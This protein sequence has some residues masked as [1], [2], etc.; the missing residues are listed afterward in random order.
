[1]VKISKNS[2]IFFSRMFLE[3]LLFVIYSRMR[4]GC[5]GKQQVEF[6]HSRF[7]TYF[8]DFDNLF[9][10][11]SIIYAQ[12]RRG[13]KMSLKVSRRLLK[14]DVTNPYAGILSNTRTWL[15]CGSEYAHDLLDE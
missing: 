14:I 11:G 10:K 2:N 1:M 9:R 6:L 12:I 15:L 3:L 5:I 8:P 13:A 7:C 4:R